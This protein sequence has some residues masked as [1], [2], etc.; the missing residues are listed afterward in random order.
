MSSQPQE[1][2]LSFIGIEHPIG[3]CATCKAENV[4]MHYDKICDLSLC[5]ACFQQ[6]EFGG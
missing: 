3:T 1:F 4:E 2:Q 5:R 6:H